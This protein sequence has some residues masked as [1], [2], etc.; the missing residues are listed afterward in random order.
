MSVH[1][2]NSNSP[3]V[4]NIGAATNVALIALDD[5]LDDWIRGNER[6]IPDFGQIIRDASLN[7][8]KIE[9]VNN[10]LQRQISELRGARDK[11]CD[12]L[13]QGYDHLSA[14]DINRRITN[15][16]LLLQVA[17]RYEKTLT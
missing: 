7:Q 17:E 3:S 16:L 2:N 5:M 1:R 8:L 14:V 13:V 4:S 15:L 10:W 9:Q 12:E 6:S 11:S